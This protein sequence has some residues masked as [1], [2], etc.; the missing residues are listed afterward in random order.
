MQNLTPI[1]NAK[2]PLVVYGRIKPGECPVGSLLSCTT[3]CL[4]SLEG[5]DVGLIYTLVVLPAGDL[6]SPVVDHARRADRVQAVNVEVGVGT[7]QIDNARL[8]LLAGCKGRAV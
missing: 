3:T 1:H 5:D 2:L 7:L 6:G 8:A 4:T